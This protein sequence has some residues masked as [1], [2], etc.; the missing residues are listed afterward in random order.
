[1]G[2]KKV[3]AGYSLVKKV[4]MNLIAE[5]WNGK[6]ILGQGGQNTRVKGKFIVALREWPL[7][8]S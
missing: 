3:V 2:S 4:G 8:S 7:E 5:K 1:L 6:S